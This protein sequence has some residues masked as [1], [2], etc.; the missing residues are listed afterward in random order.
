[1][2]SSIIPQNFEEWRHCILVE[3]G[4]ELTSTFIDERISALKND[5]DYY[6]QQ[7]IQSYGKQHYSKVL[8]WFKQVRE[9]P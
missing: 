1:M 3:C 9:M 5:G 4:L 8:A 6:T 7:F 2:K